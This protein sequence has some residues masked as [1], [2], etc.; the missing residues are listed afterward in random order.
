MRHLLQ[1]HPLPMRTSFAH[2]LVLTYALP[3]EL[4]TPL[5]PPG[6][7]LDTYRDADGT[8]HGFV[9]A[10]VVDTRALRPSFL[11]AALGR[12]MTR[13]WS[14]PTTPEDELSAGSPMRTSES[15]PP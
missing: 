15:A 11:P 5:V 8:E 13:T 6:L 10:A 2:S 9:A 7:S 1:R 3:P 4:L 12:S 14:W